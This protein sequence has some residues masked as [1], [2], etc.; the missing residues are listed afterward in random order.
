MQELQSELFID[1]SSVR[2][3]EAVVFYPPKITDWLL[4]FEIFF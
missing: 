3:L 2:I 1:L 4:L